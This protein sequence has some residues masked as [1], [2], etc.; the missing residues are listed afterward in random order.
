MF[1]SML[2]VLTIKPMPAPPPPPQFRSWEGKNKTI[3]GQLKLCPFSESFSQQFF[4]EGEKGLK[5][6]GEERS[7]TFIT[8]L[9][10]L[11]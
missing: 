7:L 1:M 5:K 3:N 4:G 6:D 8:V 10:L 2:M 11:W 9:T